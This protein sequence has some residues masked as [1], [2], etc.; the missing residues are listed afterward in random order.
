M[1]PDCDQDC[2]DLDKCLQAVKER[3][4]TTVPNDDSAP[5]P[6]TASVVVLGAFG[7]RFDQ[8]VAAVHALYAWRGAFHRVVLVGGGNVAELLGAGSRALAPS[9]HATMPPKRLSTSPSLSAHCAALPGVHDI[10]PVAG[11]EG[12]TCA[13]LPLGGPAQWVRTRGLEGD[14]HGQRLEMGLLVSSSNAI[15]DTAATVN[16]AA[17]A[18]AEGGGGGGGGGGREDGAPVRVETSDPVV[19]MTTLHQ[20]DAPSRHAPPR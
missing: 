11:V 5:S 13:L 17:A 16:A 9:Q 7:G 8:E 14:L 6:V 10:W 4:Q 12:P 19:W 3:W 18:A 20:A 1:V 15:A 2:N